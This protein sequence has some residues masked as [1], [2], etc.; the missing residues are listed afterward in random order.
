LTRRL[1]IDANI[2]GA[3]GV[4]EAATSFRS[5]V[6]LQAVRD[7]SHRVV[8][9]PAINAEWKEHMSQ[10][11]AEWFT[12]MTSRKKVERIVVEQDQQLRACIRA[13]GFGT[14]QV[15]EVEKDAHLVEAALATDRVVCSL[16]VHAPRNFRRVAESHGPIRN[17]TW[18]DINLEPWVIADWLRRGAR[19]KRAWQLRSAG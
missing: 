17:L 2:A 12:A 18:A 11:T 3:A 13:A 6:F 7:V 8:I 14:R 9:T 4:S 16:E 5:R 15:L 1:V 19:A 10:W